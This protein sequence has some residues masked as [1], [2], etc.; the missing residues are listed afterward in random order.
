MTYARN[1][2]E[3]HGLNWSR[4]GEAVEGFTTPLWTFLMIPANATGL[5]LALRPLLIQ[6]L[7]LLLLVAHVVVVAV[8]AK[9]FFGTGS[10]ASSWILAPTLTAFFYPL[11]YWSLLG[12]ETALQA[13]LTTAVVL[14]ALEITEE[15]TDRF[16]PLSVVLALGYLTRMDMALL[17]GVIGGWLLLRGGQRVIRG[18]SWIVGAAILAVG[19]GGYQ[20]F[21]WFYFGSPLPNTY[22][23]KL[24]EIPFEVRLLRGLATYVDFVRANELILLAV[25]LGALPLVRRLPRLALPLA[26]FG[27]YSLY[28]IYVGGDAWE[29]HINVRAN[30]FLAFVMPQLFLVLNALVSQALDALGRA[31]RTTPPVERQAQRYGALV[32]AVVSI[33]VLNGLWFA[34]KSEENW[35]NIAVVNRPLLVSSHQLILQDLRRLET[36]I[37]PGA[38]VATFWAGIPAYYSNYRMVDMLGYS[39][40]HVARLEPA[41]PLNAGNFETYTPGHVKWDFDYVFEEKPPDAFLQVWKLGPK[42]GPVVLRDHKYRQ[43]KGFWVREGSLWLLPGARP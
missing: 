2:V 9:R 29:M 34:D 10:A 27:A 39:D 8:L 42:R 1:V 15:H 38:R 7:S 41:K 12:M 4:E 22:Y 40:R 14:F 17:I 37:A 30:R 25:I 16:V 36:V 24:A 43:I 13:L 20:I 5:P 31:L 33:F 3:G 23:L 32:A 35:K 28:S 21:R 6:I 11:N 26:I 19:A 18:R